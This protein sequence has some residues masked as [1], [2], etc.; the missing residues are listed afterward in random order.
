MKER[1]EVSPVFQVRQGVRAGRWYRNE[2]HPLVVLQVLEKI[3]RAHE[4]NDIFESSV[5]NELFWG[6]VALILAVGAAAL[7]WFGVLA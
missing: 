5:S 7:G 2:P 6:V 1:Y 4:R 3:M